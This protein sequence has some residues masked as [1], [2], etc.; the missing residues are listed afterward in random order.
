MPCFNTALTQYPLPTATFRSSSDDRSRPFPPLSCV[1]VGPW[2]TRGTLRGWSDAGADSSTRACVFLWGAPFGN[3]TD[4]AW[5]LFLELGQHLAPATIRL[6]C[7]EVELIA[8]NNT[9]PVDA[10]GADERLAA[11]KEAYAVTYR[12]YTNM[13][14]CF[15]PKKQ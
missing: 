15:V 9:V 12:V 4:R 14:T 3:D 1:E 5:K 6:Y 2:R 13:C 11:A 7:T 8:A 10:K